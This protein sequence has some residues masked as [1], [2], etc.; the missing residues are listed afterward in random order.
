MTKSKCQIAGGDRL[1]IKSAKYINAVIWK[2]QANL[3]SERYALFGHLGFDIG[4][5]FTFSK[6]LHRFS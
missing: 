4:I 1:N 3:Y 6:G 5:F 2:A